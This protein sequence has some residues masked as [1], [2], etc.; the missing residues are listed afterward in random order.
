MADRK[1]LLFRLHSHNFSRTFFHPNEKVL[2]ASHHCQ[3]LSEDSSSEELSF[4]LTA[5][6]EAPPSLT[7]EE[8]SEAVE[9]HITP[10]YNKHKEPSNYTYIQY[11]ICITDV[12]AANFLYS[13]I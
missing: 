1:H 4:R 10:W 3:E 5:L 9:K 8:D 7:L 11:S 2:V 6:D 12:E 13:P